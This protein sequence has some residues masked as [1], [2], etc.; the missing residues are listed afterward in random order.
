VFGKEPPTTMAIYKWNFFYETGCICKG[1][2]LG[3]DQLVKLYL[4][5]F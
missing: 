1:K 3:D 2:P 4:E 5:L